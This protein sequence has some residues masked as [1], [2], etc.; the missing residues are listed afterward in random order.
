VEKNITIIRSKQRNVI[1]NA[2][3]AKVWKEMTDSEC[4]DGRAKKIGRPNQVKVEESLFYGN[5]GGCSK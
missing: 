4:K 1:T 3:K 5:S 2:E